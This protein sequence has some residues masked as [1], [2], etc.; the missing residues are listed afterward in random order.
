[1]LSLKCLEKSSL[2]CFSPNSQK[3]TSKP[4]LPG[5][6]ENTTYL[7]NLVFSAFSAL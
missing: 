7:D 5:T 3:E 6:V 4:T 1:M 2:S